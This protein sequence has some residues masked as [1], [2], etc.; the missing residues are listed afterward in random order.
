LFTVILELQEKNCELQNGD[1]G[2]P[3]WDNEESK[4]FRGHWMRKRIFF[5]SVDLSL[6]LK[7]VLS[8]V[9]IG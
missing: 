6:F 5:V 8:G 9:T 4:D 2:E 7:A 1:R 3:V